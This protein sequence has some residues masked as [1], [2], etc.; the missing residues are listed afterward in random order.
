LCVSCPV[1]YV[2][3]TFFIVFF[4]AFLTAFTTFF[5][6]AFHSALYK[7]VWAALTFLAAVACAA[8]AT[9]N[10]AL[11]ESSVA[12]AHVLSVAVL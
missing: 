8:L 7:A 6:L 1:Q 2:S 12:L 9:F 10:A 11:A 5:T 4:T 3:F